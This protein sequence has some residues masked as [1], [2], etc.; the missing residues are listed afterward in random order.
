MRNPD[1]N[2][3]KIG[4]GVGVGVMLRLTEHF[5]NTVDDLLDETQ[6]YLSTNPQRVSSDQA[7]LL[8]YKIV[9]SHMY[10]H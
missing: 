6:H 5:I 4:V 2:Y 1:Q 3:T 7:Y 9:T 8:V 10:T